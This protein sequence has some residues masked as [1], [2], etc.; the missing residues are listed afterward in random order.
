MAE[1]RSVVVTG[2]STGIGRAT[3]SVLV[4]AGFHVIPTVR[5]A[6]GRDGL[7]AEFGD[8]VTPLLM[9]LLDDDSVRA[10]GA[11]VCARGP[12]F[13]LVNNAG[14]A[15][16]GPLEYL[17]IEAFRRQLAINLTG[18][19]LVTQVLLPALRQSAEQIG[20]A[21]IVMIGS[22]GGRIAAPILGAYAASKHGLVGLT[23]SLRAELASSGIK[24]LL[25]EPGSIATPIWARGGAA[26]A[27]LQAG[28]PE[29]RERYG[30]QLDAAAKM[31][32]RGSDSGLDPRVPAEVIRRCL[33]AAHPIPRQVVG[34]EAKIIA[35]M[36]R[37]LPYRVM[38]R[39]LSGRGRS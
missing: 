29:I 9:D 37:V 18:Q 24:V 17:P 33:T 21:R 30:P 27:E 6:A 7:V 2:T 23:G 19:L 39:L 16:P 32:Q 22:I 28:R 25:V 36:V 35:A 14:A 5:S 26:G 20:D 3:V 15:V 4:E 11:E 10:M 8:A 34:R 13:G 12:L 1:P 31:S 38:S